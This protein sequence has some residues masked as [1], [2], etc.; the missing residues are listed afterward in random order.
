MLNDK[1]PLTAGKGLFLGG[2]SLPCISFICSQ[3][4]KQC[5]RFI[6]SLLN[7]KKW[8]PMP[9]YN[10]DK[11]YVKKTIIGSVYWTILMLQGLYINNCISLYHNH[12]AIITKFFIWRIFENLRNLLKVILVLEKF[13]NLRNC[14]GLIGIGAEI[15]VQVCLTLNLTLFSLINTLLS[16]NFTLSSLKNAI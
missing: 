5:W 16:T 10:N 8:E 15:H 3:Q 4:W 9:F 1:I 12:K 2:Q 13:E 11:N 7:F 6:I 14:L